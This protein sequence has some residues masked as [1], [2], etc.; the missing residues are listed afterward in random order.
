MDFLG[1]IGLSIVLSIIYIAIIELHRDR[2]IDL[3]IKMEL[4]KSD[5][6]EKFKEKYKDLIKENK[7]LHNYKTLY[8]LTK[9]Q[10]NNKKRKQKF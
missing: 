10:E 4:L 5:Y 1:Y 9:I 6:E 3:Q 7:E 8:E 2:N